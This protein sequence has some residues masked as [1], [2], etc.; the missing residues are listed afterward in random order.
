MH[1]LDR[2]LFEAE[3][4]GAERET[5]RS[6][7]EIALASELL[8][9]RSAGEL[10]QFLGGLLRRI[11]GATRAFARSDT[12]RKLGG[13]LKQ[14]ASQVIPAMSGPAG[15]ESTEPDTSPLGLEL[16]GLSAEDREFELAKA[17]V[18]FADAATRAAAAAPRA[19]PAAEAAM[20]AA[21]SAAR[22]H[23]P[24][25]L[26]PDRQNRSNDMNG[27]ETQEWENLETEFG[28]LENQEWE[29]Q[30]W[31]SESFESQEAELVNE[32]LEVASEQELEEFL[33]KLFRRAAKTVGGAISSPV[34]RA[35]T[36]TL[37][38]VAKKALPMAGG[39]LGNML[40]PGV[41]GAIGTKLGSM[42]GQMFEL[43]LEA[44]DEQEAE[45]EV[46]KRFV[47]LASTAAR[48]AARA[49][50]S[51]PAGAVSKA[52]VITAARQHAPGLLRGMASGRRGAPARGRPTRRRPAHS[53]SGIWAH[54]APSDGCPR[55]DG[56]QGVRDHRDD[57][58][59]P[60]DGDSADGD[61]SGE[62]GGSGGRGQGRGQSGRWVRRGRKI[63]I[64][65][66]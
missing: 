36:G 57:S 34:G 45:Y 66:V 65:D 54:G 27:Y 17:F 12:G 24:G 16:E 49:P 58:D 10:E 32:L 43:E 30:E 9:A 50:R 25:L 42:A 26:T 48:Q 39:V 56:D 53:G 38:N 1:D 3:A 23:L 5:D 59:Q 62:M 40:L 44:M 41:G 31:E 19:L 46:G 55:C 11:G 60:G 37:K 4:T 6:E 22:R 64:M 33:G 63:M 7:S 52:A 18:R 20:R 15:T 29:S 21:T 51:A 28:E 14:A 8:D 2:D 35:L 61:M 47:R 13:I